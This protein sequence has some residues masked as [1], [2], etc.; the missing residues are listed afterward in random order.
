MKFRYNQDK[1]A[2]LLLERG[3]GFEEMIEEIANGNLVKIT[4]HHNQQLYPNQQLLHVRCLDKIYLMP[5]VIEDNGTIFLKTLYPSRKATK[6]E[7]L[8]GAL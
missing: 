2:K 3:V 1:N 5:Y 8:D 6:A 4:A 7:L